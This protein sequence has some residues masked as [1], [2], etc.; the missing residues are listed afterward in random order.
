MLCL[1]GRLRLA[2]CSS[3][4]LISL[5]LASTEANLTTLQLQLETTRA[6]QLQ[7]FYNE[8]STEHHIT[9]STL[10]KTYQNHQRYKTQDAE[11]ALWDLGGLARRHMC[12]CFHGTNTRAIRATVIVC[13]ELQAVQRRWLPRQLLLSA[14]TE[15]RCPRR[16][17]DGPLLSRRQGLPENRTALMRHLLTRRR[18]KSR[19]RRQ[20]DRAWR[21]AREMW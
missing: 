16:Q 1:K 9:E 11:T 17:H 14:R 15:L 13:S 21:Y 7:N 2:Y 3:T 12:V 10:P 6:R 20:N 4:I 8:N 5:Y 19:C 18:D